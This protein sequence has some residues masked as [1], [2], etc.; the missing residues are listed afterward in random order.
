MRPFFA[1]MKHSATDVLRGTF[2]A[3]TSREAVVLFW[4]TA[5]L[6]LSF[7]LAA[8]QHAP[9]SFLALWPA[10]AI[11][12]GPWAWWFLCTVTL[13]ALLPAGMFRAAGYRPKE[14]AL[15][16]G[17]Y[18]TGLR[19]AAALLAGML[20]LAAVA[21]HAPSF[22][23]QYPFPGAG[24]FFPLSGTR[25]VALALYELLY[26]AQLC[27]WEFYFRGFMLFGLGPGYSPLLRALFQNVPFALMHLLKPWP[28]ALGSLIAGMALAALALR[29][30]SVWYGAAVHVLVAWTMDLSSLWRY[31]TA[32]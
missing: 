22:A 1:S 26:A 4:G 32:R 6:L 31:A 3:A 27:S 14:L 24:V 23:S 18:R 28:E 30:R 17:D 13:F 8:P 25:L 2:R 19:W 29:T 21:A 9:E 12:A 11:R 15:G 7:S 10:D 20:P 16:T 5:C